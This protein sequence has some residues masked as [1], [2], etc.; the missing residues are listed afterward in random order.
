[1]RAFPSHTIDHAS[2]TY[3][4]NLYQIS[5]K[6]RFQFG[7]RRSFRHSG[8]SRNPLSGSPLGNPE[9]V[10]CLTRSPPKLKQVRHQS[11]SVRLRWTTLIYLSSIESSPHTC[12]VGQKE[13]G[14][15]SSDRVL[16]A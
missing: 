9:V 11:H 13:P 8:E 4:G 16:I 14:W 1:M 2:G 7:R 5:R 6:P 12:R 3:E 10:G 15:P